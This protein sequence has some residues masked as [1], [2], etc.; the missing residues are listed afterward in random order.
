MRRVARGIEQKL[1][2]RVA[3]GLAFFAIIATLTS[4]GFVYERELK[5][6][7]NLLAQLVETVR[8]QAEVAVFANN[9]DI[10]QG[11]IDG[12]L[13]NPLLL[14][15][16]IRSPQGIQVQG[17][18]NGQAAPA[19]TL[20]TF[21]LFSPVDHVTNIGQIEVVMNDDRVAEQAI[22]ATKLLLG[23]I[24][25]QVVLSALLIIWAS[26][27][28]LILPLVSL[29]RH[30]A[31]YQP[32][33]GV[34]MEVDASHADDEIGLLSRSANDL[35][36]AH[37]QALNDLRELATIDALT[38]VSNRRH[39]MSRMEEELIRLQRLE[40]PH[41]AVLMLDIDHFKNINDTWGHAT[42][43]QAL[44]QLGTILRSN[45]RKIDTI[46]RLGGEEFALLLVGSSDKE[47]EAFAERL[48]QMIANTP[49]IQDGKQIRMTVSIG[50]AVLS[51]AD[52]EINT[53]LARADNALY[54]A[55]QQ[56]RD[57]VI[58]ASG[59]PTSKNEL[60]ET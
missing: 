8:A 17:G 50:V 13:V 51:G 3:T 40:Q 33:S 25:L 60:T 26:R 34:R 38:G 53:A 58:L 43:D 57:R 52:L 30:M 15:V 20:T 47:G 32:G 59:Q 23:V 45:V 19:G 56:G 7:R 42:G 46:G 55:K 27:R 28:M 29:A 41:T 44:C 49:V 35:I 39:F 48:R 10:A 22:S 16:S 24:A 37:E 14:S 5:T 31:D 11:V 54:Q 9:K 1:G 6:S 18:T 36:D 4:A 12:L 21:P 2:L